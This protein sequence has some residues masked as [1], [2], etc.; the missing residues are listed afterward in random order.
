[1]VD[2]FQQNF[3]I[4]TDWEE[5]PGHRL[6]K[7]IGHEN[8][9]N[10]SEALLDRAPHGE[11]TVQKDQAGFRSAVHRSGRSLGVRIDSRAL[12]TNKNNFGQV[13]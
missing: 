11:R 13:G 5:G 12:T 1:M 3:Q 10:S 7:K 4:K 6:L 2:R 8:P 9:M